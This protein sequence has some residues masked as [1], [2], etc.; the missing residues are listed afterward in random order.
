[1]TKLKVI[2]LI[3]PPGAG[4]STLAAALF[5]ALKMEHISVELIPEYAK[6]V[7]WWGRHREIEDQF[8]ITAKQHHKQFMMRGK[9][10]LIVTDSSIILGLLYQPEW[11]NKDLSGSFKEVVKGH[12]NLYDNKFYFIERDHAYVQEGRSQTEEQAEMVRLDLISL[13]SELGLEYVNIKADKES[14][15]NI[16]KDLEGWL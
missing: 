4:K 8:Y 1:M 3:A 15:G 12:L 6:T 13:M 5:S 10:D 9:T 11:W 2:N 16:R 14:V 7:V